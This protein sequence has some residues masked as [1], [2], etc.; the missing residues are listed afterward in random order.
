MEWFDITLPLKQVG[1]GLK[2]EDFDAMVDAFLIQVENEFLERTGSK[3]LLLL[4]LMQSMSTL[5]FA[6]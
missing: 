3:I 1:V 2:A 5:Q 4:C 6:K